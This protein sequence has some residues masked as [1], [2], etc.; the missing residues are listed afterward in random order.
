MATEDSDLDVLRPEASGQ[1]T[2]LAPDVFILGAGFSKQI[3][4]Q[5]LLLRE[6]S[7][8]IAS[9]LPRDMKAIPFMSTDVEMAMTFLARP[10]PWMTQA[11][12]L[13]NRALFLDITDAIAT[14]I[15][16]R[17]ASLRVCPGWLLRFVHWLHFKRAVVITLNYDT[18]LESAICEIRGG[19]CYPKGLIPFRFAALE[20]LLGNDARPDSLELLKLHGSVNWRFSGRES[21]SGE[22]IQWSTI[23]NLT[24]PSKPVEASTQIDGSFPLI[25]PPVTDKAGYFAH[26]CIEH[27]WKR[28]SLSLAR[29]QRI[30]CVGYSLPETDL[31]I[32]FLLSNLARKEPADF[33]LVNLPSSVDHFRDTLPRQH[34]RLQDRFVGAEPIQ[35]FVDALFTEEFFPDFPSATANGP[36]PAEIAI[37]SRIRDGQ[38]FHALDGAG[39]CSVAG[40]TQ[41]SITLLLNDAKV[42]VD[43][44]AAIPVKISW[45]TLEEVTL[46]L[47]FRL[48]FDAWERRI[49][50]QCRRSL[51]RWLGAVLEAAGLITIWYFVNRWIV[52][53]M[54]SDLNEIAE[55]RQQSERGR[56]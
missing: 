9:R 55:W 2:E 48:D 47:H 23:R 44:P 45:A 15:D 28:A 33:Y 13:R 27:L 17:S 5:M 51:G 31:T 46:G 22:L 53:P 21:Y 3:S 49:Q 19:D 43:G 11:E 6:L 34:F 14:E 40:F 54:G 30:Y 10:Q 12:R 7:A 50:A 18:L 38:E 4:E 1:A 35:P 42:P 8:V 24:A 16:Q 56:S 39:T 37:R 20:G 32:R 52:S 26:H 25:I 36:G 41:H 29:A